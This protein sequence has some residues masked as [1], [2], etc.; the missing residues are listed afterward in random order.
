MV[1][2]TYQEKHFLL[3]LPL[4]ALLPS[5]E[6][7]YKTDRPRNSL[8][9]DQNLIDYSG[10][11]VYGKKVNIPEI[12]F[13]ILASKCRL[14]TPRHTPRLPLSSSTSI[15]KGIS[16]WMSHRQNWIRCLPTTCPSTQLQM[17]TLTSF[18]CL[19]LWSNLFLTKFQKCLSI[20]TAQ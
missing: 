8:V 6:W 5:K 19:L 9:K 18:P 2:F 14:L 11:L 17:K 4:R 20:S 3:K 1:V 10:F 7:K 16:T 15:A 13:C 12:L